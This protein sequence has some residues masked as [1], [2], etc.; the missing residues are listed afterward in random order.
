M[1]RLIPVFIV[2]M[3][4]QL[5]S[6]NEWTGAVNTRWDEPGNWSQGVIPLG[7]W[8]HPDFGWDDPACPC[9][10]LT[11]DMSD[12]GPLGNNNA[13]LRYQGVGTTEILIDQNT[14]LA[15][16]GSGAVAYGVRVGNGG[17]DVTLRIDGGNLDIG[18][19]PPSTPGGDREGWHFDIG[20]GFQ[21]HNT[22]DSVQRVIMTGGNVTTNGLL[23]PEQFVDNSL[24]DPTDSAPLNGELIMS[25]GT[26][27][28]RWMNLGQLKGNGKVEMSGDATI[29]LYPTQPSNINNGGHFSFNRNWFLNGQPVPS[30]GDVSLDLS[31]NATINIF[32]HENEFT[33]TPDQAELDRYE[34]YVTDGTLTANG[35]VD[36][37]VI[38]LQQCPDAPDPLAEFCVNGGGM[39][40]TIMAP[41]VETTC[42]FDG[43]GTCDGDDI[44]ALVAAIAAGDNDLSFDLTGDGAVDLDDRDAWLTEAGA[45]NLPSGNPYLVGDATLDGVVDGQDFIAWNNNKF[46]AAASW[47]GG[48]FNADGVVD[49]QDFIA[50]N[51]TKFTSSD[52]AAVPEPATI[53]W[54]LLA[55]LAWV[56]RRP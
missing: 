5:V 40:I 54:L 14:M 41:E 15:S 10:P 49:G 48:D 32:G 27:T 3:S 37:P 29:N 13:Q 1:K 26:I 8:Q 17:G 36:E 38:M 20:R 33:S 44:D 43:N 47:T 52:L 19:V 23:I 25:G 45:M 51:N 28:G 16:G 11:P 50:W 22:P 35:G 9:Y 39:M 53:G 12:D 2:L 24:T 34:G 6:A 21:T 56:A 31:D 46:T 42:D 55:G 18:G 7:N 30:S 4:V